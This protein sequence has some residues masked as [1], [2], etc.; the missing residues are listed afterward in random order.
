MNGGERPVDRGGASRNGVSFTRT[1]AMNL[2]STV[3]SDHGSLRCQTT[4][5]TTAEGSGHS[6]DRDTPSSD[7]PFTRC[8]LSSARLA[9][10]GLALGVNLNAPNMEHVLTALRSMGHNV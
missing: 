6:D 9:G 5:H 2:L 4:A 8:P 10:E 3:E 7:T 1:V